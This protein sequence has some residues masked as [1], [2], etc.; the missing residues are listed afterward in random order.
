MFYK[1]YVALRLF[2]NVIAQN[3]GQVASANIA[4]S[5]PNGAGGVYSFTFPAHPKG[6][7]YL[8]MVQAFT[9]S[10]TSTF[11]VCTAA[12]SVSNNFSVWCRT[13][14]NGIIDG[15]FYVYTVP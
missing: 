13:A 14:A 8:V 1:P 11:V 5:R 9:R 6:I 2:A 3:T 15:S 4:I 12:H 7:D 10:T